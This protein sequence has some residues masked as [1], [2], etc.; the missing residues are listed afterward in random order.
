[1]TTKPGRQK[2]LTNL[3][4]NS[5]GGKEKWNADDERKG[6]RNELSVVET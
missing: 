4:R 6:G 3:E 5:M 1:L 2:L